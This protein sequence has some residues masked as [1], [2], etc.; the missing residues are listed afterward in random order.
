MKLLEGWLTRIDDGF[1][2]VAR[3]PELLA[4][5]ASS[6]NMVA[7]LRVHSRGIGRTQG[8]SSN[9]V[10][11]LETVKKARGQLT[12]FE[13]TPHTVIHREGSLK[14]KLYK[15]WESPPRG[16]I[17]ILPSLINRPYV[18][19][20]GKGRSLIQCLVRSGLE[21]ALVD[22]GNP[23]VHEQEMGLKALL[24]ERLPRALKSLDAFTETTDRKQQPRT[25]L[26]HC[27]GGNLALLFAEQ[28]PDFFD[29][30][31]LLTTP[32]DTAPAGEKKEALLNTWFQTPNW[33]PELFAQSV[34]YI[35][36]SA[37]QTSFLLQRPTLTARR[38]LQFASRIGDKEFRDSWLQMEVWSNDSVSFPSQIFQDLLIPLYRN[39]AMKRKSKIQKPVFSLAAMDDHIVPLSSARAIYQSHPHCDHTFFEAKG[40]HIGAVLSSRTRKEIWPKL[41]EFVS[42][43]A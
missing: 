37:L 29:K 41:V 33:N 13:A 9:A 32:I 35:P 14:L 39:N 42:T 24:Q 10:R 25:L 4:M 36:W 34:D 2:K 1:E 17:V 18:L 6:L 28:H 19:D 26:G 31:V 7:N 23:T 3:N 22:W 20:L 16:Q 8:R 12:L 40:G 15:S 27:L 11:L 5:A 21:V 30:L 38:W 43:S